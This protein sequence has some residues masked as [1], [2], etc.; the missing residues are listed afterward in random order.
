MSESNQYKAFE[1]P[2]EFQLWWSKEYSIPP[3][4]IDELGHMT[5]LQYPAIFDLSGWEFVTE[6]FAEN[7]AD[8]VMAEVR[9]TYRHEVLLEKAPVRI[10][11]HPTTVSKTSFTLTMVMADSAG[12]LCAQAKYRYVAWDRSTRTKRKLNESELNLIARHIA[13]KT[14]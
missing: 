5:A 6:L 10:Y 7:L 2:A 11:V 14:G 1:F 8:F 9:V 4:S 3:S 13:A 12:T